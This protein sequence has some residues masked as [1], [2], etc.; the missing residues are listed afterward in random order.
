MSI[1]LLKKR[2]VA[3]CVE[4]NGKDEDVAISMGLW[5]RQEDPVKVTWQGIQMVKAFLWAT[6]FKR[7]LIGSC[8][9]GWW[10]FSPLAAWRQ[11][12]VT[13][14]LGREEMGASTLNYWFLVLVQSFEYIEDTVLEGSNSF[15]CWPRNACCAPAFGKGRSEKGSWAQLLSQGEGEEDLRSQRTMGPSLVNKSK[16]SVF[17]SAI[18][19][20]LHSKMNRT[21]KELDMTELLNWLSGT[22]CSGMCLLVNI[23]LRRF[24][25]KL[26]F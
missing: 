14:C 6:V 7:L 8:R 13:A 9:G 15:F 12:A 17:S 4:W 21:C 19:L 24:K 2:V 20:F 11:E 10:I 16:W 18:K 3:E 25:R 22:D 26:W 5:D 1:K 23:M